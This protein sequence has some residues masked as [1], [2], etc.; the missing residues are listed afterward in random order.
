MCLPTRAEGD[1]FDV[2]T[3]FVISGWG[4]RQRLNQVQKPN[5]LQHATV[6]FVPR[7]I[8][9]ER[10]K[11]WTTSDYN[12]ITENML[13]AGGD[14]IDTCTVDNGGMFLF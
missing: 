12:Y 14:G 6:P 9:I 10:Y 11:N 13:C 3:N 5:I 7:S 2:G 1:A 8:C 4:F